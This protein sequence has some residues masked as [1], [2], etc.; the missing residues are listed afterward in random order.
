VCRFACFIFFIIILPNFDEIVSPELDVCLAEDEPFKVLDGRHV[1]VEL[2][3]KV[4]RQVLAYQWLELVSL[5]ADTL[6]LKN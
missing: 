3:C 5:V 2:A 1:V 6:E 4:R